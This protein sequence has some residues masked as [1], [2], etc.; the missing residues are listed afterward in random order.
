MALQILRRLALT[1]G[2]VFIIVSA[3]W[4]MMRLA[5]GDPITIERGLS[6]TDRAKLLAQYEARH[7]YPAY[8]GHLAR[9]S[10]GTS[11]VQGERPVWQILKNSIPV[12]FSLGGIAMMFALVLGLVSGVIASQFPNRW[13]DQLSMLLALV[14]LSI[15][16]FVL[17]PLLQMNLSLRWD[18]FDISG[19][20][21]PSLGEGSWRNIILPSVTLCAIPAATIA[22]LTRSSMLES[23][24]Q[25]FIR[26]A[27]AKGLGRWTTAVRH[28]LRNAV[29]PVLSY[30]GP[31]SAAVLMGSIVVES[32]FS[33][34]GLGEHF[35]K[36][37]IN[38]DYEVV[39]GIV[40]LY[41][42]L[43]LLFN[44]VIDILYTKVDPRISDI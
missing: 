33:I 30:L 38:R 16:A 40:I 18:L 23:M 21:Q 13:P 43:L 39:L 20:W 14:G 2:I 10:L 25:D 26:T 36:G 22:R 3:T 31:A 35:I 17:G 42:T 4:G 5:P 29:L 15:P 34:P 44:L 12:S 41:S 24:R 9:G 8:L 11:Y 19:W 28:G 6:E 1:V 37:A 32:V 7:N 27:R